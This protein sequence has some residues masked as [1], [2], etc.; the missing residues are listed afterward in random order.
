MKTGILASHC[1]KNL[2]F[3]SNYVSSS[4]STAKKCHT[5]PSARKAAT[6]ETPEIPKQSYRYYAETTSS[7]TP[8]SVIRDRRHDPMHRRRV[9]FL[10]TDGPEPCSNNSNPS[11]S[12]N[13][14]CEMTISA[15]TK[16]ISPPNKP[17]AKAEEK[18]WPTGFTTWF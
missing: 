7:A 17:K 4:K 1:A 5:F 13:Y 2:E 9:R 16:S 14:K 18:K 8:K 12:E 10:T 11:L 3:Y 15:N 6:F